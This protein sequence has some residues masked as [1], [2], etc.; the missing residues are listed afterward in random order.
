MKTVQLDINC[1]VGEGLVDESRLYPYISSCSIA[2]G[3]HAGNANSM[4]QAMLLARNH[5][6]RIGAH[7]S[8][9]D[10]ANFGRKS[11][12]IPLVKLEQSLEKQLLEFKTLAS[13]LNLTVHHIK[14]HGALYNE[15]IHDVEKAR[16]MVSVIRK[17]QLCDTVYM[18]YNAV[19]EDIALSN[20]LKVIYEAFGD[21]AYDEQGRLVHRSIENAV[22][23]D[24]KKVLAQV[25]EIAKIGMARTISGQRLKMVAE[26]ICI[27]SDTPKALEIL[28]YL[29]QQ[30]IK[31][32]IS[33]TQ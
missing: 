19:F 21:R 18:P 15:L 20:G 29:K 27:H 33:P 2:T 23:I 22:I 13:Q 3:G 7:P 24:P 4:K 14:P 10:K 8:Y 26:T 16:M 32:G 12:N 17:T 6:V 9:P 28:M 31:H 1:D 11:M 30:L 5:N 25:V